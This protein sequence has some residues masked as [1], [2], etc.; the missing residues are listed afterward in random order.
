M[1]DLDRVKN[2][3]KLTEKRRVSYLFLDRQE[4]VLG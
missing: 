3:P 2:K 4:A 1:S